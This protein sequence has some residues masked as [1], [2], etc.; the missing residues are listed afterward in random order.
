MQRQIPTEYRRRLFLEV[1]DGE[2]RL[3]PILH[4]WN[5]FARV[6]E[7]LRWCLANKLTGKNLYEWLR[8][9]FKQSILNPLHFILAK[10]DR[11]PEYRPF[12]VGRDF[13]PGGHS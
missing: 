12:V 3:F 5:S 2:Q 8:V 10:V 6:D 9:T 13:L 7:V 11:D 1:A 4:Q